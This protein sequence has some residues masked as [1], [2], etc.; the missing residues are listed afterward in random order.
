MDIERFPFI[1]FRQ[2]D[3]LRRAGVDTTVITRRMPIRLAH[4]TVAGDGRFDVDPEGRGFLAFSEGDDAVFWCPATGQTAT[5][6]GIAFALG[7]AAILAP[8]TFAFDGHLN[9]YATPL[10]WLLS[11]CDGCVVLDWPR[12]FDRLRDCPRIAIS[13]SL[14]FLYRRHMKPARLPELSVLVV[15]KAV[16]A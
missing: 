13:E 12:A 2:F 14:L 11:G 8:E 9:V 16:S 4:G 5:W 6:S 10:E 7:E 15:R 1:E 3:W